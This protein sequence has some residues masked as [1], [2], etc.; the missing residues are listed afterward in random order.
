MT[1][2]KAGGRALLYFFFVFLETGN[3]TIKLAVHK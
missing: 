2:A 1:A 3:K